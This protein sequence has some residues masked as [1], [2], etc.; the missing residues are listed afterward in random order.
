VPLLDSTIDDIFSSTTSAA[1]AISSNV[2][3]KRR[4]IGKMPH[5]YQLNKHVGYSTLP[6]RFQCHARSTASP[7]LDNQI[8]VVQPTCLLIALGGTPLYSNWLKEACRRRIL[9]VTH[10]CYLGVIGSYNHIY[11][12]GCHMVHMGHT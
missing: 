5:I 1:Y 11:I 12:R 10:N 9:S 6:V 2:T 8:Y 7:S 3:A 4:H